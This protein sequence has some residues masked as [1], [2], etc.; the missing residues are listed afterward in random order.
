[1]AFGPVNL[2]A[3]GLGFND[4]RIGEGN[5]VA[6]YNALKIKGLAS[7]AAYE[8][9]TIDEIPSRVI[10]KNLLDK[11]IRCGAHVIDGCRGVTT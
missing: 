6:N 10:V 11:L 7:D 4:T 1:M 8:V 2:M 5:P 3:T 9:S